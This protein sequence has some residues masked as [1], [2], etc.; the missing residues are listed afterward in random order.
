MNCNSS[1][2]LVESHQGVGFLLLSVLLAPSLGWADCA[3]ACGDINWGTNQ[4]VIHISGG[5]GTS[6]TDCYM[7]VDSNTGLPVHNCHL[8]C[9][10]C[11]VNF[12]TCPHPG[13]DGAF[14]C[15][16][17][18]GAGCNADTCSWYGKGTGQFCYTGAD[19][20]NNG[21]CCTGQCYSA[22][23]HPANGCS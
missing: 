4:G 2:R 22:A 19:C 12:P 10:S 18:N 23:C 14:D 20:P 6:L 16:S 7:G 5:S 17:P 1:E 9:A 13:W 21:A 8:G 15:V 11:T 3:V